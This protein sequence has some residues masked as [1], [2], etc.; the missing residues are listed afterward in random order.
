MLLFCCTGYLVSVWVLC[1]FGV[2]LWFVCGVCVALCF[3]VWLSLP[4]VCHVG[5]FNM[6]VVWVYMV[7]VRFA[8]WFGCVTCASDM[9]SIITMVLYS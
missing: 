1:G 6:L 9:V 7:S 4:F 3:F 5:G 2:V 8:L